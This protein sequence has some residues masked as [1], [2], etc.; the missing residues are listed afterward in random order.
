MEK[1][2]GVSNRICSFTIPLATSLNLSGTGLY[3]CVSIFFIC[4]VYGLE[5]SLPFQIFIA[6]MSLLTSIGIAGIPSA[7]IV[8][9]VMILQTIGLPA[10]GIALILAVERLLDMCRTVVNVFGNT[11]CAVLIAESEGESDVLVRAS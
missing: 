1:R 3:I 6:L 2:A 11:V 10:D 7:S 8:A 4:Q 9:I 5:L